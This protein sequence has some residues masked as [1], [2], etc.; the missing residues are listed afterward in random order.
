VS[1]HCA[2]YRS[3]YLSFTGKEIQSNQVVGGQYA[4]LDT[5]SAADEALY[6]KYDA[7]PYTK[8]A[9]SIPF[10]DIGGRAVGSE[11]RDREGPRRN[12]E[13]DH[14]RAVPAHR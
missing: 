6:A 8:T 14:C 1:F 11:L 7:P 10:V 13:S 2:H 9:G 4:A 12:R 5:L 3:P